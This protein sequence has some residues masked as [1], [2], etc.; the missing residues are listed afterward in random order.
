MSAAQPALEPT[1]R[2]R[3][4]LDRYD[5]Q[6]YLWHL[7]IEERDAGGA[8]YVPAAMS[9]NMAAALFGHQQLERLQPGVWVE[10]QCR[11][12]GFF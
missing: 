10:L 2:I 8:F 6:T 11:V 7:D 9:I 3:L 4:K 1:R 5:A 12:A